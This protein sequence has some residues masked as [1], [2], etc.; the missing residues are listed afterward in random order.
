VQLD[1]RP[2]FLRPDTP[3]EGM[4]V[5][6]YVR[7]RRKDPRNPLK[8][9]AEALGLTMVERDTVPSTRRAHEAAELARAQGKLA[10]MHAALLRRYWSEG[11]DLHQMDVLRAAA[12]ESGLDPDELQAALEAGT[13]REAVEQSV[14]EAQELGIDAVPTFVFDDRFAVQGAQEQ[15]IFELAM[16]RLGALPR[17]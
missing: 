17:A 1:W 16:Q 3:P 10:P 7:A 9:R 13:Y 4:P 5:P 14:R 6:D 2:F 8:R 15:P 11:Q 12:Q